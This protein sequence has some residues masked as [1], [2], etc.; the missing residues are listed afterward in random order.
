MLQDFGDLLVKYVFDVKTDPKGTI[1]YAVKEDVMELVKWGGILGGLALTVGT[2]TSAVW[3]LQK[4]IGAVGLTSMF[5]PILAGFGQILAKVGLITAGIGTWW[6]RGNVGARGPT[7]TAGGLPYSYQPYNQPQTPSTR[8]TSTYGGFPVPKAGAAGAG[9][10]VAGLT[11]AAIQIIV[12]AVA[13]YMITRGLFALIKEAGGG[14]IDKKISDFLFGSKE[15][16]KKKRWQQKV[17][18]ETA[19]REQVAKGVPEDTARRV[20]NL[21]KR[22]NEAHKSTLLDDATVFIAIKSLEKRIL[23]L[24]PD[25]VAPQDPNQLGDMIYTQPES[26]VTPDTPTLQPGLP[27]PTED[28][29]EKY[30]DILTDNENRKVVPPA[31]TQQPPTAA[32]KHAALFDD[33]DST[34]KV[35]DSSVVQELRGMREDNKQMHEDGRPHSTFD[36]GD[37]AR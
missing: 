25:W 7:G 34:Q 1:I 37:L 6:K 17:E 27:T 20:Q 32:E 22:L 4:A 21:E 16:E 26:I 2:V 12:T 36:P 31:T 15:D 19:I 35:E 28:S 9:M 10:S 14:D 29:V 30:S 13:A 5:T 33:G 11:M 18:S 23:K 24:K 8:T 3:A